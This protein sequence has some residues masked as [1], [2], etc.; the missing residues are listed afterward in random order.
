VSLALFTGRT[1]LAR[2]VLDAARAI[3]IAQQ[4]EPDGS[5]PRELAR[6]TSAG[7]TQFNLEAFAALAALGE[8][9]GVDLWRYATPDGR[10]IRNAVSFVL[11]FVRDGRTWPHTQIRPFDAAT[12]YPLFVAAAPHYP[13]LHLLDAADRLGGPAARA[14]RAN[15]RFGRPAPGASLR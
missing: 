13:D 14:H 4:I 5:M 9:A 6:T 2:Q 1:D 12:Y 15:L 3:R 11:P 8:R 10:S 7:Y